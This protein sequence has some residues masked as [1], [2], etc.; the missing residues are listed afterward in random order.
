MVPLMTRIEIASNFSRYPGGRYRS[1]GKFSG[2]QFRDDI[3]IP[4]LRDNDEVLV[5]LDGTVGYGSSFL[6]EAFGGLVR[7]G[8]SLDQLERKLKLITDDPDFSTYSS[9]IWQY[10]REESERRK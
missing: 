8:F 7:S 1:L 5:V 6:E 4:T 9:E 2:E 10:I 3:L